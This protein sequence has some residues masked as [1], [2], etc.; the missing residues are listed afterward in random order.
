MLTKKEFVTQLQ[1]YYDIEF[2]ERG[3]NRPNN[4]TVSNEASFYLEMCKFTKDVCKSFE[5]VNI[6]FSENY[7]F[8]DYAGKA[9]RKGNSKIFLECAAKF[10]LVPAIKDIA[11]HYNKTVYQ[12]NN[13]SLKAA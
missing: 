10:I 7:L 5:S 8:F 13:V 6:A 1:A 2:G 12:F 4:K 11:A 9:G 3:Y